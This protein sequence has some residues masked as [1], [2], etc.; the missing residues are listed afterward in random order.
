MRRCLRGEF[1]VV[2]PEILGF[3]ILWNNHE[4]PIRCFRS[5]AEEN[6]IVDT[7]KA[8]VRLLVTGRRLC[9]GRSTWQA[10]L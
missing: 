3:A 2:M 4:E 6:Q 8:H 9:F 5:G 10:L 7:G 1:H